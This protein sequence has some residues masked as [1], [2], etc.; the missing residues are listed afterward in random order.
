[1]NSVRKI[2]YSHFDYL[3]DCYFKTIMYNNKNDV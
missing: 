1:M 2:D 3:F